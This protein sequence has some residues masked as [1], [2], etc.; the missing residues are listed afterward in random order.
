[1]P[2][3]VQR[4]VTATIRLLPG[5]ALAAGITLIAFACGALQ[6]RL[7]PYAVL[8]PLVLALLLGLAIR[9]LW[10]PDGSLAPGIAWSSRGLLEIAIVILGATLD[11]RAIVDAGPKLAIAVVTTVTVTLIVGIFIAR[12]VGLSN[13]LAVLLAVGNAICGNS[14]IAAVAPAIRAKKEEVASA[15]ALTAVLGVGTVLLLPALVPIFSLSDERYGAVAGLSVYAVP[16]VLAAT[17]PVSAEAGSLASLV[18][19][20]RVL[21]LGPVVAFFAFV[22]RDDPAAQGESTMPGIRALLPWFVVGFI[23]TAT[24]RTA[25]VVPDAL[26]DV[27]RDASRIG[28]AVAMAALGLSVDLRT[29]QATGPRVAL[30][31]TILT[32]LLVLTALSLV[33][34]LRIG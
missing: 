17:I 25:G 2:F 33:F 24:L 11:L 21:L 19:L 4:L 8:E 29:V 30:V 20:T 23:A 26:S 12:S 3:D 14:A 22:F 15:I 9:A 27:A 1:M 34:G 10:T 16:Q 28:T 31:V 7:L 18:K 13:R 5:L 6:E 32:G